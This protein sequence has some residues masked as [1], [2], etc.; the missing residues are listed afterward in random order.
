LEGE[1]WENVG[2][3]GVV[4]DPDGIVV[5]SRLPGVVVGVVVVVGYAVVGLH[6]V[7]VGLVIWGGDVHTDCFDAALVVEEVGVDGD[8]EATGDWGWG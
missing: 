2:I 6:R 5:L 3:V 8:G 7:V 1:A 4:N